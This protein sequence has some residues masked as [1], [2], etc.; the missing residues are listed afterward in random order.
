MYSYGING[1]Q[2]NLL[3]ILIR[4]IFICFHQKEIKNFVISLENENFLLTNDSN[5]YMNV[6][7]LIVLIEI[8]KIIK[9]QK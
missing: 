2:V 1:V 9:T 3:I 7:K 8:S 5:E 6:F 4:L